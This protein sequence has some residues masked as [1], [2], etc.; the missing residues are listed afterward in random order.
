MD[1]SELLLLSILQ[2]LTE[3]LPISSSGHLRLM[4]EFFGL[5]DLENSLDIFLHLGTLFSV[6]VFFRKKIIE[7]TL[8]VLRRNKDELEK[9]S[10]ILVALIPTVFFGLLIEKVSNG[11]FSIYLV[12]ICFFLSALILILA[13]EN[14]WIKV[15]AGDMNFRKSFLIGLSQGLA[16]F[17]G[18]SRS[19]ST[20]CVGILSG[21]R[22]K[23]AFEFSFL[24]SIP[25]ILG[26]CLLKAKDVM[27]IG[28]EP[29]FLLS[30]AFISF[31]VGIISLFFLQN[32]LKKGRLSIFSP[33][34]IVL[35]I[36]TFF[37]F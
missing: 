13:S 24:V 31:L 18:I 14:R 8:G 12:A 29:V 32:L 28:V 34:L 4:R 35:G 27:A 9:A 15:K 16:A 11:F 10:H 1:F 22:K 25:A 5:G 19:G 26:A 23:E 36:V 17:P 21:V 33:Y 7:I 2:G 6:V 30:G 3:F 20:I 37:L